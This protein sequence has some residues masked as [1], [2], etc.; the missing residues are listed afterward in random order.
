MEARKTPDAA[1]LYDPQAAKEPASLTVNSDLL[2]KARELGINLSATL[3][4]ALAA[5]VRKRHRET[6]LADNREAI[7]AYNEHVARNGVWSEGLR[8]F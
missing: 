6:W 5:Q 1:G 3:E 7:A 8:S 2:R 4:E